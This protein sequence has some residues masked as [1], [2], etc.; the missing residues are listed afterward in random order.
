MKL[1]LAT[2]L[3]L[4]LPATGALAQ[5][6]MKHDGMSSGQ[7]KSSGHMKS[8]GHMKMSAADTRKMSACNKMSETRR[9]KDARCG[10]LSA[11]HASMMKQ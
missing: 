10:K 2:A 11:M 3:A 9:A 7:M 4:A 8:G 1:I 5:D 6:T